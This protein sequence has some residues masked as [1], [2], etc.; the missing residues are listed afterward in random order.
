MSII[1]VP[2]SVDLSPQDGSQLR[3]NT[4]TRIFTDNAGNWWEAD[5]LVASR[6]SNRL[7]KWLDDNYPLPTGDSDG[8]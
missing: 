4:A 3:S 2:R 6:P 5:D 7:R 1:Q 8:R